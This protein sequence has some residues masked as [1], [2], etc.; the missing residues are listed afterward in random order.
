MPTILTAELGMHRVADKFVPRIQTADQKQQRVSV[1][2]ELRHIASDDATFLSRVITGD[3]SW[4]YGSDPETKQQP[5]Q[6]K[7]PNS[8]R[9]KKE[10]QVKSKVKSMLIIFFDIKEIVHKEFV[11]AGQT[12]NSSHYCDILRKLRENVQRL[13]YELWRQTNWLLHHDNAPS[14]SSIFTRESLTN[15]NMTCHPPTHPTSLTWPPA[16]FLFPRLKIKLKGRSFDTFEVIEAESEAVM[17]TLIELDFHDA[18]KK[19]QKRWEQC[20]RAEGDY[21]KGDGGQ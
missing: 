15:N 7:S 17:N 20:I 14:H 13:R 12:V 2:E 1:C 9:P 18:F 16:T 5:S 6:W 4:I 21:F 10:R 19:W 11:L 3:E 8:P